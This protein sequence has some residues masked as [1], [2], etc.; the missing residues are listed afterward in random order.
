[1]WV[2]AQDQHK[3]KPD[4]EKGLSGH[5]IPLLTKK[6]F[7]ISNYKESATIAHHGRPHIQEWLEM[8]KR[9]W[10]DFGEGKKYDQN[11]LHEI[12]QKQMKKN[13]RPNKQ[14]KTW[15]NIIVAFPMPFEVNK[16]D[17]RLPWMWSVQY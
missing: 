11:I 3:L 14:R 17:S 13:L 12:L 9:I 15:E 8:W 1:M 7:V 16:T 6:L 4:T 10:A 5:S 2:Q